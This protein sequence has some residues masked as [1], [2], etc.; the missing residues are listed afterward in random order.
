MAVHRRRSRNSWGYSGADEFAWLLKD[1][2]QIEKGIR[3][4]IRRAVVQATAGFVEDVRSNASWSTRIPSAVK[5]QTSFSVRNP[6]IRVYVDSRMAPHARPYE[7][8]APGGNRGSF[9]HPVHGDRENWVTQK[10]RPFFRPAIASDREKVL[11]AIQ[12][13]LMATLPRRFS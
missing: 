12:T 7:G 2:A 13:A 9:R 4:A 8:M 5:T 3:P 1:F 10:T 6:G 11:A